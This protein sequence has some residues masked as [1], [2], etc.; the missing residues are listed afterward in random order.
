[1]EEI[2]RSEEM[3]KVDNI[4]KEIFNFKSNIV[5]FPVRHHSPACSHH[6]KNVIKEY[7]PEIILIEGPID[8]NK[9]KNVLD[10]E[11][12]IAPF[13]IYY[14]YS[15]SKGFIDENKEKYKCYYPFLDYSP[16]LVAL[17]EG[18]KHNIKTSFIDLSYSEILINSS[19]GKGLL[20]RED[21]SNYNDDYLFDKNKFIEKLCEEQGC[22]NFNELWEK[23]FEIEGLY[24][25]K[26][27][28]VKNML[29]YCYLTRSY[30]SK[31]ELIEEGCLA[32]EEFMAEKIQEAAEKYKK[33]LVVTGGFHTSGIL[34]LL[35]KQNKIK[36]HKVNK[37]DSGVYLMPYSM[38]ATNQLNGYA[39]GMPYPEFYQN[40]WKRIEK[41]EDRPYE[42][43]VLFNIIKSGKKV[44]KNDGCLSTFDEICAFNMCKGL[45]ELRG[46]REC[47]VYELI[48][49]I[50]S[51]FIKG[52]LNISTEDP[53][54]I[55]YKELTGNYIGKLCKNA[56]VP[57]IVEDFRSL[58]EKYRLKINSTIE[59]ETS[60]DIF[61]SKRH[62]EISELLYRMEFLNTEFCKMLKGPNILLK[63]NMNLVREVWKYKWNTAVDSALIDNSV[64]GG[65]LKDAVITIIKKSIEENSITLVMFLNY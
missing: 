1:M 34:E 50:T 18:K 13:A 40:V 37:E 59:Q 9:I 29:T 35:N 63:K 64:Y 39:S 23:L 43:S 33:I 12:S 32:R 57:P 49:G 62:R 7:M 46:K 53:L 41:N 58:C 4:F 21:K 16:E 26:E 20:K 8:G 51:S 65:T 14:S 48:D 38:E 54:K 30:S 55:L 25:S 28:F 42:A 10:H 3:D 47:G 31:E 56:E 60:L 22:R 17:R 24:I 36:L 61:S 44:R 19:E 45:N 27:D 11:E 2:L 52:D 5:F 6:L 15:D